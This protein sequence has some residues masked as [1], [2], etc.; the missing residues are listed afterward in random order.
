M[1]VIVEQ[2]T[3]VRSSVPRLRSRKAICR[4]R[5]LRRPAASD[6]RFEMQLPQR[7]THQLSFGRRS[8]PG[9]LYFVTAG[10]EDQ[11]AGLASASVAPVVMPDER[12]AAIESQRQ[13]W[14]KSM[15]RGVRD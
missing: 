7:R 3:Q 12:M 4:A 13:R 11:L 14:V 2:A 8:V 1:L 10:T 5:R 6:R 15:G 9:A